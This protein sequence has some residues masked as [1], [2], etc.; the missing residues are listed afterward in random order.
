VKPRL[1][2]SAIAALALFCA[3]VAPTRATAQILFQDDFEDTLV[4]PDGTL[5]V[6]DGPG[7]P[8]TMYL[9]GAHAFS[10]RR[11]LELKYVPGTFGASFMYRLFTS[12]EHI[13]VRWYQR[14]SPGF[15]WEPSATKM[16]I[17]R[18]MGGYPQF[19]P[20]VMWGA[21]EFAIQ[22]Q[23]IAEANWDARNFTQ[24]IGTPVRFQS[25]RWYCIEVF[26][27]LNAPGIA[28]GELAAW[29]DG[30]LKL[31]YNGRAFRGETPEAPAPST[32]TI[33]AF[34][35]TGYYGG[36]TPVLQPQTSWQDDV[37]A[38]L[39][40]IGTDLVS[41][42]FETEPGALPGW[43]GPT[44]PSAMYVSGERPF[45]GARSLE[46][47]YGAG[48]SGVGYAY[49]HFAKQERVYVR[50][51]QRWSANFVW[52]PWSTS[53]IA[54]RPSSSYPHFYPLLG[55]NGNAFVVQAQVLAD[56]QWGSENFFQNVGEPFVPE[57]ERWVC[58]EVMVQLNTPGQTD[59]V[60]AAWIDDQPKLLY[61]GRAF[62]GASGSDPSPASARLSQ[63]LVLG[64]YSGPAP[65]PHAQTSWQDDFIVSPQ[66]IGCHVPARPVR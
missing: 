44:N 63:L 35:L 48:A 61:E 20:Q 42:D 15:I 50:W 9:T 13:Y 62:R 2:V 57:P 54:L 30:E 59:G 41:E 29:I 53:L 7:D 39:E 22:A 66:R 55:G 33:Q 27:K 40:R 43:D 56:R 65:V 47:A 46:L 51:F 28:D 60:L 10:G 32:A 16:A 11:S 34:G 8:S 18:P 52:A 1:H 3:L 36:I 17:L 21:G 5:Q 64:Q 6:W 23:V 45:N 58:F 12:R 19:Y 24:N 31:S 26:V 14:W 4:N 49:R 38:S 25:D 37:V